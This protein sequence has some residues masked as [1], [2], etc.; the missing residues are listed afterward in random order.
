[1][2]IRRITAVLD[3]KTTTGNDRVC[4]IVLADKADDDGYCWPGLSTIQEQMNCTRQT[5]LNA[6]NRLESAGELY[7]VRVQRKGSRYLVLPGLSDQQILTALVNRFEMDEEEASKQLDT[8]HE[9]RNKST[10][11]TSSKDENLARLD[12]GKKS[13]NHTKKVYGLDQKSLAARPDPSLT[14]NNPSFTPEGVE[15]V[16]LDDEPLPDETPRPTSDR[17]AIRDEVIDVC[18]F[19]ETAS[20]DRELYGRAGQL[21]RYVMG[22]AVKRGKVT[23]QLPRTDWIGRPGDVTRFGKWWVKK[24]PDADAPRD[25]AKFHERW[26][27]WCED[28]EARRAR[29]LT[30]SEHT[31]SQRAESALYQDVA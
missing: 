30:I 12:A 9:K 4:L 21:T 13:T 24:F 3:S 14:V 6:I 16:P 19:A 25:I 31:A 20:N 15:V 17:V 29:D 11:H 18:G 2:S 22:L 10:N 5:A 26:C 8:I 27:E 1:M 28:L 23:Y 7:S